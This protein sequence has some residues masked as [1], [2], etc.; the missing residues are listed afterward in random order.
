[1][2]LSEAWAWLDRHINSEA[3]ASARADISAGDTKGLS[4]DSITALLETLGNPH[5]TYPVIHVTGTVGKGSTVQMITQLLVAMGLHVGSY[6]SPHVSAMNERFRTNGI[7]ITDDDLAAVLTDLRLLT[8]GAEIAPSYFELLTAASFQWFSNLAVDVAV[9]EVGL[10][11]RF[12]ATNVVDSQVAVITN[13]GTDHTNRKGDFKRRIA[14]EKAG[15]IKA[16]STVVLG[17]PDPELFSIFDSERSAGVKWVRRDFGSTNSRV[18]VDGRLVDIFARGRYDD[19]FV[20]LHGEHQGEN[21]ALAIAA[22]EEFFQ[23]E[24]PADVVEEALANVSLPGRFEI[25]ST[26]PL[27]VLDAGHTPEAGAAVASTIRDHLGAAG[28]RVIVVGMLGGR[29]PLELLSALE[30]G[31]TDFV[32]ATEPNSERAMD[33]AD[34]AAAAS[35]LGAS[36]ESAVPVAEAIDRA[37]SIVDGDEPI[38]VFGSF[39]VVG[40][41]RAAIAASGT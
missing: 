15:I 13:V 35:S 20:S 41:A 8:E 9:V 37:T 24:L 31:S 2:N 16:E 12:D 36:V 7:E 3:R 29:D 14:A 26:D 30:V 11:G 1:M 34:V 23:A 21:A 22:T 32:I 17:E 4:L 40:E 6:S 27:I 19:V 38:V 33:V 18:A 28:S 39:Y 5:R 25:V 10:L